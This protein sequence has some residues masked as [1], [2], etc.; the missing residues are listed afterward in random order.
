MSFRIPVGMRN[1]APMNARSFFASL[2]GMTIIYCNRSDIFQI[3]TLITL[4]F[5]LLS[6]F[7]CEISVLF[8]EGLNGYYL[9]NGV[10]VRVH[11]KN[12]VSC[13]N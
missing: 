12:S 10:I 11:R 4:I 5:Y 9:F 3:W 1:L 13:L 2:I 7:I 8:C 6:L